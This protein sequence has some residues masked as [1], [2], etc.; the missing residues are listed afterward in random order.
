MQDCPDNR[1]SLWSAGAGQWC[2][3]GACGQGPALV[4]PTNDR[5]PVQVLFIAKISAA[6]K[7]YFPGYLRNSLILLKFLVGACKH[8][9]GKNIHLGTFF[10]ADCFACSGEKLPTY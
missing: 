2:R 8:L 9:P 10:M 7:K 1:T 5:W 4:P 6:Q 3:T